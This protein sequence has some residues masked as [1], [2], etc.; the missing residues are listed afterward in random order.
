ME[1]KAM[2]KAVTMEPTASESAALLAEIKQAFADMDLL[3]EQMRRDGT[4]IERS[5]ARTQAILDH[6]DAILPAE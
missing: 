3:R 6:L 4:E 2:A 5:R 1:G